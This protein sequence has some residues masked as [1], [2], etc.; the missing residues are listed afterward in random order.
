MKPSRLGTLG[1]GGP[2]WGRGGHEAGGFNYGEKRCGSRG[3]EC[4][5][6]QSSM[7][8]WRGDGKRELGE[9]GNASRV[10]LQGLDC[11]G[12]GEGDGGKRKITAESKSREGKGRGLRQAGRDHQ[13]G[14]FAEK[15]QEV[16]GGARK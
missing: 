3:G 9:G 8:V 1:G 7:G 6:G 13:E 12:R 15:G 10:H 4:R 16:P 14:R 2:E 5:I 11:R